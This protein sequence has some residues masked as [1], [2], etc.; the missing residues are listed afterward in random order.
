MG[1]YP[2]V[3]ESPESKIPAYLFPFSR[4]GGSLFLALCPHPG[5]PASTVLSF[6]SVHVRRQTDQP[7]NT[8]PPFFPQSQKNEVFLD[9][10]ERLSVLIA[11]N[12]RLGPQPCS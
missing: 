5:A 3:F 2:L 7:P 8:R 12:V 6:L 9:V 4:H 11:S 1:S 10:V